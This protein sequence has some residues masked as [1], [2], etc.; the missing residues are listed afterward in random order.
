MRIVQEAN[1]G[2]AVDGVH[3]THDLAQLQHKRF[4]TDTD[5]V[6]LEDEQQG[7]SVNAGGRQT[8]VHAVLYSQIRRQGLCLVGR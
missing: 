5:T 7:I 3:L 4:S 6:K 1:S 8:D 2:R